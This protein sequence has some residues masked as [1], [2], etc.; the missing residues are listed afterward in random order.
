MDFRYEGL[1]QD[2]HAD[3][4]GRHGIECL[5]GMHTVVSYPDSG[6]VHEFTCIYRSLSVSV[7]FLSQM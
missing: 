2:E 5:V 6:F 4:T 7:S 3:R 1:W